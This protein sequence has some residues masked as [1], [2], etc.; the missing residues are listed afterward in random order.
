MGVSEAGSFG[1]VEPIARSSLYGHDFRKGLQLLKQL[2]NKPL[3]PVI[4]S[5]D[6]VNFITDAKWEGIFP[7]PLRSVALLC[8]GMLYYFLY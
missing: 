4:L 5:L 1:V 2:T 3:V 8:T 7:S 6:D